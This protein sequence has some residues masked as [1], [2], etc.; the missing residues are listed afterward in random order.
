MA[1][2]EDLAGGT[3]CLSK[4][5]LAA[6]STTTISTTGTTTYAIRGKA[7]TK[8]AISNG[9]TPTTDA[10]GNAFR[11]VK[12]GY[13]SVFTYGLNAANDIKVVQGTIEPLDASYAWNL[14]P[15]FG[16]MPVDFCPIGYLT[17]LAGSTADATTGW[18]QGTND[19]ASV[20]GITY[21]R[22]DIILMPD[23]PQVG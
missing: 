22:T 5:T 17:I 9:A 1:N 11:G 16:A 14:A 10:F 15:Q 4:V 20:T 2:I 21:D 3:F 13:G 12:A 18:L 6:G 19:Q 23:R 7:Y 8:A